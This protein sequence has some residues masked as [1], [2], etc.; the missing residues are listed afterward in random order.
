MDAMTMEKLHPGTAV[1]PYIAGDNVA[2]CP[3]MTF[4][5][6]NQF[7]Q[8]PIG[9]MS[10]VEFAHLGTTEYLL[11]A[12][13]PSL[14]SFKGAAGSALAG[15]K[16]SGMV[17][18]N[19]Y[20]ESTAP[21]SLDEPFLNRGT[22]QS[23]DALSMQRLY[24]SDLDGFSEGGFVWSAQIDLRLLIPQAN[25]IGA[26]YKGSVFMGQLPQVETQGISLNQLIKIAQQ[27]ELDDTV[28]LKS[29]V[30]N[31]NLIYDS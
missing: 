31:H 10:S 17:M 14:S 9:T 11:M 2:T 19:F 20:D 30:V 5:V 8:A 12:F 13:C 18:T 21:G 16:L 25:L 24:G 26:V 6:C 29:A 15:V 1:A 28:W 4:D 3:T 22:F 23:K 7:D 27:T